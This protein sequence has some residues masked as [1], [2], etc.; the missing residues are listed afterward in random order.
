MDD[1]GIA[2]V[3]SL[4]G[5]YASLHRREGDAWHEVVAAAPLPGMLQEIDEVS[6][7]AE[8]ELALGDAPWVVTAQRDG[9]HAIRAEAGRWVAVPERPAQWNVDVKLRPPAFAITP[10]GLTSLPRDPFGGGS[11]VVRLDAAAIGP[12]AWHGVQPRG[13]ATAVGSAFDDGDV[14]MASQDYTTQ[15][16]FVDRVRPDGEV[17][18]LA[19]WAPRAPRPLVGLFV[20]VGPGGAYVVEVG[21]DGAA[22]AHRRTDDGWTAVAGEVPVGRFEA[23]SVAVGPDGLWLVASS[24]ESAKLVALRNRHPQGDPAPP[25]VRVYRSAGDGWQDV[26][27][28]ACPVPEVPEHGLAGR[29]AA[30]AHDAA[31]TTWLV[32]AGADVACVGPHCGA[33]RTIPLPAV[34]AQPGAQ[35]SLAMQ[36]DKP[37]LAVSS[38]VAG[39]APALRVWWWDGQAWAGRDGSDT[40]GV[41]DGRAAGSVAATDG[42]VC[43]W[44]LG[45]ELPGIR[46]FRDGPTTTDAELER[47]L[48]PQTP[49]ALADVDLAGWTAGP[50]DRPWACPQVPDR[51]VHLGPFSSS[52]TG[53]AE[54]QAAEWDNLVDLVARRPLTEPELRQ[55]L[56]ALGAL[57]LACW[58]E[59]GA[60]NLGGG[61]TVYTAVVPSTKEALAHRPRLPFLAY[62]TP[63]RELRGPLGTYRVDTLDPVP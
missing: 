55:A 42:L 3:L 30:I 4:W 7:M 40:E 9:V 53:M 26:D 18:E 19:T 36:G 44:W 17:T 63:T 22:V 12:A 60:R 61:G 13:R 62:A 56:G 14:L 31:G 38:S 2:W 20:G 32:L 47:L 43:A 37:V 5:T 10:A 52:A 16:V 1:D 28:G 59:G 6:P 58:D 11:T 21:D 34:A 15:Q 50:K 29:P 57:G 45:T 46:C 23:A 51:A 39:E 24:R 49:P 35:P 8:V 54:V 33:W 48:G 27:L 41:G 25:P